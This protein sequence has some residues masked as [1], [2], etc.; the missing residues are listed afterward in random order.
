[1]GLSKSRLDKLQL[2]MHHASKLDHLT[3]MINICQDRASTR[4]GSETD[5]SNICVA[6]Q[7]KLL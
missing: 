7:R 6:N 1:M 5:I 2:Q 4:W 3:H